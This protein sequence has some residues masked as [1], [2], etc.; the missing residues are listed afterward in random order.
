MSVQYV[1]VYVC[2]AEF[3]VCVGVCGWKCTV[4]S[5]YLILAGWTD[6][7][8]PDELSQTAD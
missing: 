1:Y 3:F 4:L 7:I 6:S 8:I 2:M 5:Y